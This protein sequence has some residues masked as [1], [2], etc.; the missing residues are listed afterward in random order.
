M[1][2][3]FRAHPKSHIL[4]SMLSPFTLAGATW[5]KPNAHNLQ[6]IIGSSIAMAGVFIYSLA[7]EHFSNKAKKAAN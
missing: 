5:L 2:I 4:E 3:P 7:T 1:T 6:G